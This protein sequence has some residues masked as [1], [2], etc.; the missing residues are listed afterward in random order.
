MTAIFSDTY[1]FISLKTRILCYYKPHLRYYKPH[2]KYILDILHGNSS[3]PK[4][5]EKF[6]FFYFIAY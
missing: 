6:R 2:S 4:S 1:N 3:I 5:I